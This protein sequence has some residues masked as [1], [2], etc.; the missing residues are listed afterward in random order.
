VITECTRPRD[1]AYFKNHN[2]VFQQVAS[3][4]VRFSRV[5]NSGPVP[6]TNGQPETHTHTHTYCTCFH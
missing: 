5:D 2:M 3:H 6:P 4:L 1:A